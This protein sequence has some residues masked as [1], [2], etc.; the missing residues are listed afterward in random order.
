MLENIVA[1]INEQNET[2]RI[3]FPEGKSKRI[4]EILPKFANT[5]IIPVLVFKTRAEISTE[6]LENKKLEVVVVEEQDLAALANY[7]VELRN[8]KLTLS[9]AQ[10]LVTE[11]N[12]LAVLW[13]KLD[14]AQGMVGGIEYDTK[15]ILGPALKI[16]K[17]KPGI[18]LVS[19]F[20]LMLRGEE[21]YIFTDGSLNIDPSSEE[22]ADIAELGYEASQIFNFINPNLVLLS[23]STKGSGK[24]PLVDKVRNAYQLV[25]E[26][27]LPCQIDG[28]FQFD[29]AW[30]DN[31]RKI[32]APNSPITH[33]ADIYVFPS[34]NA[35]NIGYKIAQRM[36]GYQAVGPII[37][38]LDKP[39]ND[40]SRGATGEEIYFTT[41][42]TAYM[43]IYNQNKN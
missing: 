38:G 23:F 16:I 20:F 31:I 30:D 10:R 40:L 24:G 35:A 37:I 14:K 11:C 28:E 6:I 34:L 19:S 7:L 29:A 4:Q 33:R 2:I 22:L 42:V 41:I 21:K 25:L 13:V 43:Y 5:K 27:N 9:E 8:G 15:D 12:Y 18:K 39:V 32:K 36:G 17:P 1:K 3:V 26:K